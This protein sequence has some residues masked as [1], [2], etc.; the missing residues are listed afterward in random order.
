MNRPCIARDIM[1]TDLKTLRPQEHVCDGFARL[2]Q[3]KVSGAPVI[4]EEREYLGVFS[5]KCCM[6]AL[7]LAARVEPGGESIHPS[8]TCAK[9]FMVTL[10]PDMDIFDAIGQ[11][12]KHRISG[13]PVLDDAG[14]FLG[15]LS[16]RYSMRVLIDAAYDQLPTSKPFCP[17]AKPRPTSRAP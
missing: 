3:D 5:E 11:L 13:A 2:L 17:R 9:D 12:L 14:K 6:S 7:T 16:E 8:P 4:D 10:A 15:V 1:V